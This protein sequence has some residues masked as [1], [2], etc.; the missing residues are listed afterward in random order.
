M[1]DL[2]RRRFFGSAIAAATAAAGWPAV[3]TTQAH[4]ATPARAG[5]P[6]LKPRK[7]PFPPNDNLGSYEPAIS[8][9][10]NTIYFARFANV[11]DKRVK[12]PTDLFVTRRIR[13]EGEW[14]GKP[15]DWSPAERLSDAVNSDSID[16]EPWLTPDGKSLYF[17]SR[18]AGNRN[19]IFV[20]Q[21]QPNGQW[22]Q[23]HLVAGG[24]INTDYPAHCFMPFNMPGQPNAMI[25]VSIRPRAPGLP[26]TEGLY[27][28]RMV[29]GE[30][31]PVQ[32]YESQL[33]DSIGLKCRFNAVTRDG[34]TL[35][36]VS[37]HD[38]G[39]FHTM[40][41]V[42]YDP[43]SKEWKGPIVEAPF[44]DWNIDG[45]CPTFTADGEKMIWSAGYDHGPGVVSGG[46]TGAG[47]LLDLFWL[48]TSEVVA[49]YKAKASLEG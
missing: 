26:A 12:G 42:H 24:N 35:G 2:P 32:R 14:P 43:K 8:A 40:M 9:D 21:L 10:A 4:A 17:M 44:N 19:A 22:G 1:S 7:L 31:Q 13:Q 20:T 11:G 18:R 34:M 41:F 15:G 30:W 28:T 25:F 45:A 47:D 29:N 38:F 3:L 5:A 49:Y 37:V 48:P 16:Q 33:L 6:T 46:S 36:V 23:A 27:T 39:K